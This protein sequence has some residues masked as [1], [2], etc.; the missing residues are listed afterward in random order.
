[1]VMQGDF[2][3]AFHPLLRPLDLK[4]GHSVIIS[5]PVGDAAPWRCPNRPDDVRTIQI[6][7]NRFD[8]VDG[9]PVTP[10]VP[11]GLCGPLTRKAIHHFQAKWGISFQ[12]KDVKDGIVDREG[13]T[14]RRLRKGPGPSLTPPEALKRHLPRVIEV[15][16]AARSA[17]TLVHHLYARPSGLG[18]GEL[19]EAKFEKHFHASQV[20]DK[21]RHVSDVDRVYLSMLTAIGHVP[22]GVILLVDEPPAF[23]DGAY[24]FTFPGGYSARKPTD[25]FKT[26]H[27][28]SIYMCPRS[29]TLSHDGFTYVLIHEL[30][31]YV[32]P[33]HGNPHAILDNGYFRQEA[34]HKYRALTAVQAL[35]NADSYSQFAFEAA[36]KPDYDARLDAR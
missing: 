10:L 26:L 16:T 17:L 18:F 9:G 19:A 6:A 4:G 8:P 21:A 5:A 15:L 35:R 11:D 30:A 22:Q 29:G 1:M 23:A 2:T 27:Q 24:M 7:L 33:P 12:G 31:H 14:I 25:V 36:G 13:P 32:G 34:P 20:G 3:C 28:G